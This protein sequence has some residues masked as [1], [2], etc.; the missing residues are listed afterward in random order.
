LTTK[1]GRPAV[2]FSLLPL[3]SLFLPAVAARAQGLDVTGSWSVQMQTVARGAAGGAVT[4]GC[5]FQGTANVDQTGSQFTGGIDVTETSGGSCPPAMSANLNGTVS[6]NQVSMGAV[7]G[8][9]SF[10]AATFTGTLSSA[11]PRSGSTGS[12]ASTSPAVNPGS[13]MSGTFAV[14]SGPFTGTG[15][16]WSATS[17]A[18]IAA[19]PAVGGWGLAVLAA[20][21]LGCSLWLLRRVSAPRVH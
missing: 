14:T 15:G 19:V 1:C 21:L 2:A 3:L 4:T 20:L 18:R 7:M 6:G 10:G 11:A 12:G 9:P 13:T 17:L 5:A 8:S 16:T